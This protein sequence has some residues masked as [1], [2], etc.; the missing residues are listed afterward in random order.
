[1]ERACVSGAQLLGCRI[2]SSVI[3]HVRRG[4]WHLLLSARNLFRVLQGEHRDLLLR[5]PIFHNSALSSPRAA[6]ASHRC[7]PDVA[8]NVICAPF[9]RRSICQRRVCS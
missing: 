2:T 1:M 9:C 4:T 5:F 7:V 6:P 8:R 3:C